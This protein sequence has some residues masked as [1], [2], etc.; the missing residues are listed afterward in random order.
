MVLGGPVTIASHAMYRAKGKSAMQRLSGETGGRFFEVG[1]NRSI[2]STYAEIE[3]E[4]RNQYS[5]GYTSNH[6]GNDQLYRKIDLTTKWPGVIVQTPGWLL[7]SV[8]SKRSGDR[9]GQPLACR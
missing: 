7:S 1:K 4:L 8:T 2:E 3:E 9:S 6:Q 5:L